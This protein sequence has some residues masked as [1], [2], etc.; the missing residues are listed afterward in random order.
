MSTF[1]NI[2]DEIVDAFVDKIVVHKDYFE[3]HLFFDDTTM[4]KVK[5]DGN[6]RNHDIFCE[7]ALDVNGSTGCNQAQDL[8]LNLIAKR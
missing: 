2:P 7:T 4:M 5:I 3:W 1:R 6:K 8:I